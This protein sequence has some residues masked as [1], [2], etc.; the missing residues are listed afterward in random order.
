MTRL[1]LFYVLSLF[2]LPELKALDD[3]KKQ[4]TKNRIS[5]V[6]HHWWQFLEAPNP[7]FHAFKH[8]F[9]DSFEILS[10]HFE[11]VT[12]SNIQKHLL[13]M[14][15][16][17]HAHNLK[18]IVLLEESEAQ[19]KA[20]VTLSYL[21]KSIKTKETKG[22]K[23]AY[24]VEFR[25][26]EEI[27]PKIQKITLIP[28][29]PLKKTLFESKDLENRLSAMITYFAALFDH[30]NKDPRPFKELFSEDFWFKGPKIYLKG[31]KE[32]SAFFTKSVKNILASVHR[33]INLKWKKIDS[34]TL[35][36][37]FD[38]LYTAKLTSGEKRQLHSRHFWT[39]KRREG[40]YPKVLNI[41][42]MLI[43]KE[44]SP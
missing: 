1:T 32:F 39:V 26:S 28:M 30:P 12:A 21:T 33:P 24:L 9:T 19:I 38:F 5:S 17:E 11:K 31:Y 36:L 22:Y 8:L 35:L 25:N 37:H 44:S 14:A 4:N 6:L 34:E 3:F 41:L 43:T 29:G 10:P 20:I 18:K 16:S 2:F 13:K 27:L 42:V 40:T 23:L 7:Q 15:Y